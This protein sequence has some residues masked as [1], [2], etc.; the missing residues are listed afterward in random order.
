M[1]FHRRPEETAEICHLT[2]SL[3]ARPLYFIITSK[4]SASF[5]SSIACHFAVTTDRRVVS[6]SAQVCE[7][8]ESQHLTRAFTRCSVV[9][10]I[11][12]RSSPR[13]C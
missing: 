4:R 3:S 2:K 6:L 1:A 8:L 7:P 11:S 5:F 9:F 13:M 10:D 12:S